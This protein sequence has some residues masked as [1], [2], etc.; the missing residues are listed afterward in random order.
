MQNILP[1]R[2]IMRGSVS[3]PKDV[4]SLHHTEVGIVENGVHCQ[5]QMHFNSSSSPQNNIHDR[6]RFF[7]P[8]SVKAI[9]AFMEVKVLHFEVVDYGLVVE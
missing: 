5:A 4:T 8:K 3:C 2:Q 1:L 7:H 9:P 6:D